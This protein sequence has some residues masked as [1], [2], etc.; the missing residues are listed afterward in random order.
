VQARDDALHDDCE[1]WN[2]GM[3]FTY[4]LLLGWCWIAGKGGEFMQDHAV[5]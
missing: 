2:S 3:P 5:V 4:V 1:L